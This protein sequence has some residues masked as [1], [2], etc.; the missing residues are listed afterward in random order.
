MDNNELMLEL[1]IK[2]VLYMDGVFAGSHY[3]DSPGIEI[4]VQDRPY[5]GRVNSKCYCNSVAVI[6]INITLS[7]VR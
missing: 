1:F 4:S 2:T 5:P 7:K 6:N 3:P